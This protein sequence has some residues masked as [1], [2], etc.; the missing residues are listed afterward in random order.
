[1]YFYRLLC[2]GVIFL[3]IGLCATAQS[4]KYAQYTTYNGLPID[5][6]YAAAQNDKGYMWFGTDFGIAKFDGYLFTNYNRSNGIAT[7]AITDIVYAGGDSCIFIAYPF[8]LQSIQG[9]GT[10][11]TLATIPKASLQ[12]IIKHGNSFYFYE[13]NKEVFYIFQNGKVSMHNMDSMFHIKD[14]ILHAITSLQ[15]KGILFN[16][17]KGIFWQYNNEIKQL[18]PNEDV[19]FTVLRKN[20]TLLSATAFQLKSS[21][22]NFVFSNNG[23]PIT[24]KDFIYNMA[25]DANGTVWLRGME[26]GIYQFAD[27]ILEE[28]SSTLSLQNK[29]VHKFFV[30]RENNTWFCTDGAGV[31]FKGANMFTNYETQDG[32]ANNKVLQLLQK[33]DALFIGTANGV[34][35]KKGNSIK[36]I[37]FEQ[38]SDGLQ[39]V[40][41]LFDD[42]QA[43]FGICMA[44]TFPKEKDTSIKNKFPI[45]NKVMDGYKIAHANTIMAWQQN[46]NTYWSFDNGNI[47]KFENNILT[48]KYDLAV[49]GIRKIYSFIEFE[50]KIYISTSDGIVVIEN[51][52]LI[53]NKAINNQKLGEVFQFLID[54]KNR[55]WIA[56]ENGLIIYQNNKYAFAPKANTYGGNYCKAMALDDDNKVW[57]A[58]WDGI[59]VTDGITRKNFNTNNGLISKTCHSILYDSTTK[60][61]Y[62]GTDNGLSVINKEAL[63]TAKS[64]TTLDVICFND[65]IQIPENATLKSFQTNLSFYCN[66]PYFAGGKNIVYEYKLD[67]AN[68]LISATPTINLT[69]I[70]GGSH[71]LKL[72]ARLNGDVLNAK[73]TIFSFT[74]KRKFY[75]TWWFWLLVIFVLQYLLYRIIN[76]YNKKA[77]EKKLV[78]QKQQIELTTLKQQAFSSLM[79]PHFIFNALNSIQH[80]INKQDRQMAN[81][82]LSDFAMLVRKSFDAAQKPFVPLEDEIETIRL[83]LQLEQMRFANKFEYSITLKDEVEEEDW[84]LPSMVLQPFLENAI[85]HGIAPLNEQ[86]KLEIIISA[87]ENTLYITIADNGIGIGKSQQL[88]T[89]TKH[90]SKGMYLIKE[91]LQLLS[92]YSQNPIELSINPNN[93]T[94][95]N[96]GTCITLIVPQAVVDE[97]KKHDMNGVKL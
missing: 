76:H 24:G 1:M 41:K 21:T 95:E 8:T 61:L 64:L 89:D 50:Q 60:Q 86:G 27:N 71:T 15:E 30:D 38:T 37:N 79:N 68:W 74:I 72:R 81:K 35:V 46:I 11:H 9:N 32:L 96:K 54:K 39:Y 57:C 91:R 4:F 70:G 16:T 5:N 7:K 14:L 93:D 65:S 20:N 25:E 19:Y 62:I 69:N 90:K 42:V 18:L 6:V 34:S 58:S 75:K 28:K 67:N 48:H 83:Y 49:L 53:F 40:Y 59:F 82:Y 44:S 51:E 36:P 43:D 63:I 47:N 22:T 2:T 45:Q 55:L 85:I 94:A 92:R 52:K 29:V 13:R 84:M 10:V 31:L 33:N 66:V 3:L 56:T 12:Q 23:I 97:F 77:R 88:K 87:K 80:Y 73:E 17:S 26:K 78:I